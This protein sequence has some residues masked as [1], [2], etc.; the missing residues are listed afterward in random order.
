M[1]ESYSNSSKIPDGMRPPKGKTA[2]K[3]V[4]VLF[5]EIETNQN[6]TIR[7]KDLAIVLLKLRNKNK[8]T[9]PKGL[10]ITYHSYK[11]EKK[12]KK[13]ETEVLTDDEIELSFEFGPW[14]EEG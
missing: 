10:E 7:P 13:L 4:Q 2:V 11:I 6:L 14:K 5:E 9:W 8:E 1:N 12:V 3:K